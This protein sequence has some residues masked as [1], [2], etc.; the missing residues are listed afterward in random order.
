MSSL[1]Y[2]KL[3]A[4]YLTNEDIIISGT[5]TPAHWEHNGDIKQFSIISD[6]SEEYFIEKFKN[7]RKL[8]KLL[9]NRVQIKGKLR[10]DDYGNQFIKIKDIKVLSGPSSLSLSLLRTTDI[11]FHSEE[12]PSAVPKQYAINQYGQYSDLS[13]VTQ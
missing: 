10:I 3:F 2:K 4:D 5:L 11:A 6:L 1:F 8:L 9:N 7:K 12:F 13:S